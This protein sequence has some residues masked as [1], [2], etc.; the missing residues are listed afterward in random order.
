MITF[1]PN[2][3]PAESYTNTRANPPCTNLRW[4]VPGQPLLVGGSIVSTE[5]WSHLERDFG[6][7]HVLNLDEKSDAGFVPTERLLEL[8]V[9]DQGMAI[10][11]PLL[12]SA[13]EFVR[14]AVAA[15]GKVYIHSGNGGQRA[16]AFAYAA[17]RSVFGLPHEDA[18]VTLNKGWPHAPQYH[19]GYLDAH[20]C[21]IGSVDLAVD[22]G[23][24]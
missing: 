7:T 10:A 6:I 20:R 21:A 23:T 14:S 12:Q 5:D 1:P 19:Y 3:P 16:P 13:C 18:L 11:A 2:D 15:G 4:W 17:L 24:I 8:A 22:E 9:K